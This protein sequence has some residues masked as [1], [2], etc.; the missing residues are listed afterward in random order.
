M[1]R[2]P[3]PPFDTDTATQKVRMA[4]DAWNTRNPD[5]VVGAY[6]DDSA[7]RNRNGFVTGL[8]DIHRLLTQKWKREREYR[9]IKELWAVSENRIAVRFTYE[10]HVQY[11]LDRP[12][13]S[14]SPT[15]DVFGLWNQC[16]GIS[17]MAGIV[18]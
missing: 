1:P 11:L 5:I 10:W 6:T 7:W 16:R 18:S 17:K 12:G 15:G 14:G 2:P 8:A 13:E 3:F 9:L 4:E